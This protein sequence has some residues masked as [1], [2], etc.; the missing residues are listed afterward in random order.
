MPCSSENNYPP[1]P[2]VCVIRIRTG[3]STL[4]ARKPNKYTV[5]GT[6]TSKLTDEELHT[7]R[8]VIYKADAQERKEQIRIG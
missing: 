5:T 7:I 1:H 4:A 6:D 8:D 2:N 3:W